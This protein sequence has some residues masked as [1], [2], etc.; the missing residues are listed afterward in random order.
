MQST[1]QNK[2]VLRS[3]ESADVVV[4]GGGV[5]GCSTAY[6]LAKLEIGK[7][8]L[9]E[10][11][12]I[13]SGTTG[14][15]GGILQNLSNSYARTMMQVQTVDL[16]TNILPSEGVESGF[17]ETGAIFV[18]RKSSELNALEKMSSIGTACGVTSHLV[19][20]EEISQLHPHL[21]TKGLVGGVYIPRDG[22]IDPGILCSSLKKAATKHGVEIYEQCLIK[23]IKTSR[24]GQVESVETDKGIIKTNKVV[25]CSGIWAS[26]IA[27]KVGLKL[28]NVTY[29]RCYAVTKEIPGIENTPHIFDLQCG[30][31]YKN[32]GSTL[33]F[34]GHEKNP[35]E[36]KKVP[37]NFAFSFTNSDWLQFE[38][39][40]KS[41]FE[42]LP[43]IKKAGFESITCG[44]DSFT[45]D[46]YPL[47][48]ESTDVKGFFNGTSFNGGG[49]MMSGGAG[50]QLAHWVAYGRPEFDMSTCD[51]NRFPRNHDVEKV[52][53]SCHKTFTTKYELKHF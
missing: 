22:S 23:N 4:I 11:E 33:L 49:M 48:G 30:R 5:I 40:V 25:N 14:I 46:G 12:K 43:C 32:Q 8:V 44:P 38:P 6:H 27:E 28:P 20:V 26:D 51:I 35:I 2:N 15:T 18:T 34:G 41:A 24:S 3:Q 10:K 16:L 7:V 21:N 42:L 1:N 45:P 19:S 39:H 47:M 31:Y 37:E 53:R 52:K 17:T 9:V 36:I 29:K 50:R 13:G